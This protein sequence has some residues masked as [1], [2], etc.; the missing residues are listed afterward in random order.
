[1]SSGLCQDGNIRFNLYQNNIE[2]PDLI[3]DTTTPLLSYNIIKSI[4]IVKPKTDYSPMSS[5][6]PKTSFLSRIVKLKM[7][8]IIIV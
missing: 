4:L 1:M 2:K 3:I 8:Y 5:V 6:T 7:V